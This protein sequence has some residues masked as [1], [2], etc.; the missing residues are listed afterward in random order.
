MN[1]RFSNLVEAY[2]ESISEIKCFQSSSNDNL[3]K[4]RE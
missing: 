4:N 2:F 1:Y 3:T